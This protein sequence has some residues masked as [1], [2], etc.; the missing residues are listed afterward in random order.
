VINFISADEVRICQIF[1]I[2]FQSKSFIEFVFLFLN[3]HQHQTIAVAI[4]IL[5]QTLHHLALGTFP[6]L[7]WQRALERNNHYQRRCKRV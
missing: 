7:R 3:A 2:F 6:V 5:S 4:A 1:F